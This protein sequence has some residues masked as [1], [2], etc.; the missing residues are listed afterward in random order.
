M[1]QTNY[2]IHTDHISQLN[3]YLQSK[4]PNENVGASVQRFTWGDGC[5]FYAKLVY[6][7][8]EA[9]GEAYGKKID[10]E[11]RA[12]EKLLVHLKQQTTDPTP[13]KEI[14]KE[15]I[16]MSTYNFI[17]SEAIANL[18]ESISGYRFRNPSLMIQ[19]F[20]RASFH[21]EHPQFPHNELLEYFGDGILSVVVQSCQLEAYTT[22]TN[23]GLVSAWNESSLSSLKH[24]LVNKQALAARM[25]ELGLG[26]HLL[27]SRG[28]RGTDIAKEDSVLEDLF[29]SIIGAI[30]VD[31]GMSFPVTSNAVKKL[32]GI[33]EKLPTSSNQ[34]HISHRNDLQEWCQ[35]PKRGFGIPLYKEEQ[36]SG[37]IYRSTVTVAELGKS[38]CGEG[39]NIKHARDAAAEA[40][41]AVIKGLSADAI[42]VAAPD[43]A[44]T[45]NHIGKLQELIQSYG[46]PLSDISYNDVSDEPQ[47]DNS[48]LF[49][50]S[51]SFHGRTTQGT[52]NNKK[53]AKQQ[54]AGEMLKLLKKQ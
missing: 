8:Y 53:A 21:N 29:E 28:D 47:P 27:L 6:G 52:A 45:E 20:T 16:Q 9:E 7:S 13:K 51:C 3:E 25:R 41:M 11:Q 37:G 32:L 19:A 46:M 43:A 22:A 17:N 5:H 54:A 26:Q 49:T 40:M 44:N 14:K 10:A 23:R 4:N 2:S 36:L 38:V 42:P 1:K 18:I 30:W 48:H 50:V 33:R 34:V 31:S 39:K 15:M 24:S 12:A 35:D